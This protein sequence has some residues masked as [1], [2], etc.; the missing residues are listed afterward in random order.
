MYGVLRWNIVVE[1]RSH[2]LH[3]KVGC[4]VGLEGVIWCI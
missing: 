4:N 3:G 2:N 1:G